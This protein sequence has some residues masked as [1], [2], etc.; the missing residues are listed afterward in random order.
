MNLRQE[1]ERLGIP[2]TS[3]TSITELQRLITSRTVT[4]KVD[5]AMADQMACYGEMPNSEDELCQEC[6][7][8]ERC[9]RNLGLVTLPRL[10]QEAGYKLSLT[11]YRLRLPQ[12]AERDIIEATSWQKRLEA[13][14]SIEIQ[15]DS[16]LLERLGLAPEAS[17]APEEPADDPTPPPTADDAE[18]AAESE[19]ESVELVEEPAEPAPVAEAKESEPEESAEPVDEMKVRWEAERARNEAVGLLVPGLKLHR[20]FKGTTYEVDVRLG[21]YVFRGERYPTLASVTDAI[22]GTPARPV[23][24]TK[25]QKRKSNWS[26]S[27]FWARPLAQVKAAH[28]L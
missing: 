20:A 4:D 25:R 23:A 16:D 5:L 19:E 28:K 17:E 21:Y 7:G 18:Q 6:P 11:E 22:T 27:R 15:D 9:H 13:H 26:A 8:Q 10:D 2:F 24:G 3:Q 12:A 1:A 14:Q